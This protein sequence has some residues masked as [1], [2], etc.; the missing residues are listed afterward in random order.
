[1]NLIPFDKRFSQQIFLWNLDHS[2][3]RFWRG[4]NKY[5]SL[6]ECENLP[7]VLNTEI[8]L[9]QIFNE[10]EFIGLVDLSQEGMSTYFS[11]LIGKEHRKKGYGHEAL[12][13]IEKYCFEI[14]RCDFLQTQC[15]F[16]DSTSKKA[17]EESNFIKVG[18]IEKYIQNC[19]NSEDAVFYYKRRA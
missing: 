13:L 8:L 17:L 11:L 2:S 6:E 9:I 19:G 3:R 14:K 1:M 12:K 15:S 5:L 18:V 16:E 4:V 10:P 7:R